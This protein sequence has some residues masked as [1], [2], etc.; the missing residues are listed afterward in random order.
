MLN[1]K[2]IKL[3]LKDEVLETSLQ[4]ED[5]KIKSI[6]KT[7]DLEG[8]D[9]ANY[10]LVPGF[11]DQHI[12]GAAGHD[13][14]DGTHEAVNEIS[15]ALLKE[16]TTSFLGTTMT[17]SF[18]NIEKAVY[19]LVPKKLDGA[20]LL[21]VHLEGPFINEVFKGAQPGEFIIN[22]DLELFKNW[23]K[24]ENVKIISLAVENDKD[25]QLTKYANANNIVVSQAHT[26]ATH[27]ESNEGIKHGAYGFTHA[28]NAMSKLHHRD[29]GVV[30]TMLLNND[31]YAELIC[32]GIHVSPKAVE[33]LYKNK[34][35]ENLILITDSMRAKYLPDGKSELGGQEVFVKN[36]EARLAN[37]SLAG[38][39]LKMNDG[40]RNMMKFANV[41][42][43]DAVYMA[44][45]RPAMN[46]GLKTKG[47]IKEG[48]DADLT[49]LNDKLEVV[50]TIVGGEILYQKE[51]N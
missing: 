20:N 2:N 7:N 25:Y 1:F 4:V 26:N 23:N 8:L 32:D 30:G 22:S 40:L 9:N 14:M 38:S 19:N 3:V 48:F 31:A 13:F 35:R 27:E 15:K 21:G 6:G 49:V 12:H 16:G 36:N 39:I 5:G 42:I 45:T 10:Y 24:H 46:L 50:M 18:D 51:V 41:S 28:Y 11:I 44:S 34:G 29:I 17:Q 47:L 43:V 37:G 33:L